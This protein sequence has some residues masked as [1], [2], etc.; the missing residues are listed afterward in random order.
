MKWSPR[1]IHKR[2]T[3]I[4]SFVQRVVAGMD[5]NNQENKESRPPKKGQR[6]LFD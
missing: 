4:V 3:W 6:K 2:P 5:Q 1:E